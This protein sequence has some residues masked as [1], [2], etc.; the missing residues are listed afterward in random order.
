MN[1]RAKSKDLVVDASHKAH[2]ISLTTRI[3]RTYRFESAHHLPYL[4]DGHK[5]KNLHGHNYRVEIIVR[6][7]PDRRGFV[8]DFAEIDAEVAPLLKIVDHR[9]LNDVEGLENPT[10]EIIAAWFFDRITDCE[11]VR[12][13]ENDD[14]WAEVR[15]ED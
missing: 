5:C 7:S 9:L 15:A 1:K 11:S 10:A 3:G 12:V 13:F 4:A 6:G 8:R 14:C 2:D